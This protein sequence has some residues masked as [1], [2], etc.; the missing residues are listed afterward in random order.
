MPMAM[1]KGQSDPK[2][3]KARKTLPERNRFQIIILCRIET[4]PLNKTFRDNFIWNVDLCF[5]AQLSFKLPRT[6]N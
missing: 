4:D 3:A 5:D 1:A 6:E 2:A